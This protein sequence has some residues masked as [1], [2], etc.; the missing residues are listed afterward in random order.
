MALRSSLTLALLAACTALAGARSAHAQSTGDIAGQVRDQTSREGITLAR[1]VVDGRIRAETDTAGR[2]RARGIQSGWHRVTANFIGYRAVVRDSVLIRAGATTLLDF[3]LPRA[4]TPLE[5]LVVQAVDS[6]LDP[7]ATATT[8]R[9]T[10]EDLRRLPVSSLDEALALQAGAVGQSY[11]GGRLGEQSFILD[12]LGVKNQL[13]ASTGTLGIRL[14]PE[15][16]QEASLTTNGFSARYGQALSGLV[17][18]VTRDGGERWSGRAAYETDR[19][20]GNGWD[21][22]LDRMLFEAD[23]PLVGGVRVLA[24]VD[25]SGRLDADPVNA[26]SSG[27]P[28][29]PRTDA[30]W[31]LP[32]NS[33]EQLDFGGKLTIPL[34]SRQTLRLFGLRS[35][36]QRL[37]YD[38]AYKYN[39]A[40]APGQRVG[41]TL[42]S[43]HLQNSFTLSGSRAFILDLRLG[44]FGREFIRGPLI[45]QPDYKFGAFTA[46]PFHF[47]GETIARNQDTLA[48][49][50]AVPGFHPPVASSSTPWGVPA[51]FLAG[52]P[53]GD[54]GWN[55]YREM[56]GQLDAT[57]GLSQNVDLMFGGQLAG[58]RVQ[59]FQ[60]VLAYLPVGDSVPP[61]TASNFSPTLWSA[62]TEG[63]IRGT[64]LALTA[65]VRADH[66]SGGSDLNTPQTVRGRFG[67]R[68]TLSPR[69]AVSTVLKGATLVASFGKFSQPPDFQYLVDAAFDDTTRT[70]RFRRG[71]PDLGFETATQYE[72]S[73]RI[74]PTNGTAIRVGV[75]S[76]RLDGLVA[77]V[78]LG[79]NPDSTIF[80]L[81]D[82]GSVRGL[83][84]LAERPLRNGWGVRVTYTLQKATA[85]SSNAFQLRQFII[86]PVTGD[87]TVPARVEFPL[88]YD[89]RH[90][91]TGILQLQSNPDFGPGIAGA[92][93]LA[94]LE[95]ASILRYNSGLPFSRVINDTLVGPPNDLRLPATTT[96]DMLLRRPLRLFG[97]SAGIY[98]DIRNLFNHRNQVAARR[99]TGT[100]GPTEAV[101]Q[102]SADS[103]YQLHPEPIPYESPRYRGWA[104]LDHN[105]Y[106]DGPTELKPLYLDAARDFTQPLFVYGPPRQVRLG[107]EVLF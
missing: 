57:L 58:E 44:Y 45:D 39:E 82:Y 33:G 77:S 22:G 53:R 13:D 15:I 32:H 56:R 86:D 97:T 89:R 40:L 94:N 83:E 102:N 49:M 12:G 18:V 78:P 72:L 95:F 73:L 62:Y 100:P 54:L 5:P 27:L 69:F 41:G 3:D 81:T 48:A 36:N 46:R 21:Y 50:N 71:N 26:P 6:I 61:P 93:P 20:F 25:A 74:R 76:K 85:T 88:D 42:L 2:Y 80:A 67:A 103:L 51:L 75:Y 38:P 79:V 87:T 99:D 65:G 35:V 19:P 47:L 43:A 8:Q 16:L 52:A 64:D 106:V 1:I 66:F 29:D 107:V 14:P 98:L 37:L 104:D 31:M 55:K 10:A 9:I 17:N 101:L 4:P 30:P 23:G 68:T 84:I 24:V 28:R 63:Q 70:G 34:G 60:R 59:T 96:V 90:S 7:L 11:R 92:R 91:L 105:G